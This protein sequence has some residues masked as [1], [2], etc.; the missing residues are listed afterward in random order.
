MKG[1]APKCLQYIGGTERPRC[2]SGVRS[3][4]CSLS[5]SD[6]EWNRVGYNGATV[7]GVI[8]VYGGRISHWKLENKNVCFFSGSHA[9]LFFHDVI[10][11]E[12]MSFFRLGSMSRIEETFPRQA[13][14]EEAIVKLC[15]LSDTNDSFDCNAFSS[16][17]F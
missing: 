2:C 16:S 10:L 4:M 15:F 3:G 11:I 6:F 13:R 8:A 7:K 1:H 9:F 17:F 5:Q 12:M 14:V